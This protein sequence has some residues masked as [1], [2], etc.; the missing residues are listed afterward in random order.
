MLDN[1]VFNLLKARSPVCHLMILDFHSKSELKVF[2]MNQNTRNMFKQIVQ[3][4]DRIKIG[5]P[6][7]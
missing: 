4:A 6:G 3:I 1:M 2:E 7:I 5:T